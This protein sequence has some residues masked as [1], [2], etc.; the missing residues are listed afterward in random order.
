M[1]EQVENI[2]GEG[3]FSYSDCLDSVVATGGRSLEACVSWLLDLRARLAEKKEKE[4]ESVRG[5]GVMLDLTAAWGSPSPNLPAANRSGPAA[6]PGKNKGT[7]DAADDG[8]ANND[9]DDDGSDKDLDCG[10]A[11]P[12][13]PTSSAGGSTPSLA[14]A[15]RPA[16]MPRQAEK[17]VKGAEKEMEEAL[18][19]PGKEHL[20]L[21]VIGH[22]DAGKSTLMGHLLLKLRAVTDKLIQKFEKEA[23]DMGKESFKYA[24]VM[25]EVTKTGFFQKKKKKKK[26]KSIVRVWFPALTATL[27]FLHAKP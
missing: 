22:V 11:G 24:W 23:R 1:L 12:G 27:F 18:A 6:T 7:A 16:V 9:V 14:A 8:S 19:G 4:K 17:R 2:M 21:V 13:T 10:F 5:K 26:K 3:S 25:D 15:S 20:T